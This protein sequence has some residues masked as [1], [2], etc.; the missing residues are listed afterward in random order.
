MRFCRS[1][2]VLCYE[3]TDPSLRP[4]GFIQID[5]LKRIR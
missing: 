3:V 1:F 4:H 5:L 2:G